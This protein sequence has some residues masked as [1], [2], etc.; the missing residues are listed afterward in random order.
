MPLSARSTI[1]C[2]RYPVFFSLL[3]CCY[4]LLYPLCRHYPPL[5]SETDTHPLSPWISGRLHHHEEAI[6]TRSLLS[7]ISSI[8]FQNCQ[9]PLRR[10][11]SLSPVVGSRRLRNPPATETQERGASP[12]RR[13]HS[14]HA[15]GAQLPP[16]LNNLSPLVH[17]AAPFIILLSPFRLTTIRDCASSLLR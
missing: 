1:V 16:C 6:H 11:P 12:S 13:R 9:P 10:L 17:F 4:A 7:T 3:L 5:E 15:L 2:C 14:S 8:N